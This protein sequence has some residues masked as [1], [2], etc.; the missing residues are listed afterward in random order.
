MVIQQLVMKQLNK[1]FFFL[2]ANLYFLKESINTPAPPPLKEK[3][4]K[5]DIL[6]RIKIN[7]SYTDPNQKATFAPLPLIIAPKN[8]SVVNKNESKS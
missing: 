6:S 1:L 7:E 2:L 8:S 4:P 3:K 5:K